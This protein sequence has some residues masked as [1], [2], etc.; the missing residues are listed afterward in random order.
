MLYLSSHPIHETAATAIVVPVRLDGVI[1]EGS[2]QAEVAKHAD[3]GYISDYQR[4]CRE[5][6]LSPGRPGYY[7]IQSAGPLMGT[8]VFNL[9]VALDGQ[10][11]L[12]LAQVI[13]GIVDILRSAPHV[14]VD[15]VA[16]GPIDPN[17][18]WEAQEQIFARVEDAEGRG[19]VTLWVYPP[20]EMVG[21]VDEV[22][23]VEGV[24]A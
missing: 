24:S 12:G 3:L 5:N 22:E 2:L 10:R 1:P 17:F 20:D 19:E 8:I 4:E 11:T 23:E 21:E 18:T 9:P 14:D 16:I 13:T 6:T 15:S 7:Q